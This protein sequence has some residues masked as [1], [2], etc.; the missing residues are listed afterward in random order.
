MERKP[1]CPLIGANGNIYNV[2]GLAGK[3]LRNNGM[4]NKVEEMLSRAKAPGNDYYAALGVVME[5]VE[6]VSE[7]EPHDL[8]GPNPAGLD[9]DYGDDCDEDYNPDIEMG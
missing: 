2:L 5:Y 8:C 7:E 3:T 9:N 6:P 1:R 4:G